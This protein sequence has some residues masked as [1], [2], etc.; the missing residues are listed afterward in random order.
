MKIKSILILSFAFVTFN[1][2]SQDN[3]KKKEN[4]LIISELTNDFCTEIKEIFPTVYFDKRYF[5]FSQVWAE[6]VISPEKNISCIIETPYRYETKFGKTEKIEIKEAQLLAAKNILAQI[7][8]RALIEAQS[9]RNFAIVMNVG[10]RDIV[11]S[12]R[13]PN[14]IMKPE[15]IIGETGK[16]VYSGCVDLKLNPT[17]EYWYDGCGMESGYNIVIHW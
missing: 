11:L 12:E 7:P 3:L 9:G 13:Y 8:G 2:Y 16:L 6:T 14:N 10:Y 4:I 5:E 17:L 15:W 1:I